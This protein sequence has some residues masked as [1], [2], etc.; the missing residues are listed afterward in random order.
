MIFHVV[1]VDVVVVGAGAGVGVRVGVG[2]GVGGDPAAATAAA[3]CCALVRS[4]R[5]HRKLLAAALVQRYRALPASIEAL[6]LATMS[7][8]VK[9]YPRV[10]NTDARLFARLRASG[11]PPCTSGREAGNGGEGEGADEGSEREN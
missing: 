7:A 2:F 4:V 11:L 8:F 1:Q 9:L 5:V 10:P 3:A 6:L